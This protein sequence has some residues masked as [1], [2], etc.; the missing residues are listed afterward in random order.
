MHNSRRNSQTV[1]LRSPVKVTFT[2]LFL[3]LTAEL[4]DE[5]VPS[6]GFLPTHLTGYHGNRQL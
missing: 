4:D 5:A 3:L 2:S 6:V 1:D